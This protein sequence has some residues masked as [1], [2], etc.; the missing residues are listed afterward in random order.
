[1]VIFLDLESNSLLKVSY[2]RTTKKYYENA[3]EK[4]STDT[5]GNSCSYLRQLG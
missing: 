3:S 1:V 2:Y 5:R 4:P